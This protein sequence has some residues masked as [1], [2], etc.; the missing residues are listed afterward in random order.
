MKV[1]TA[2]YAAI[3]AALFQSTADAS[4]FNCKAVQYKDMEELVS[5][6]RAKY[7]PNETRYVDTDE[8]DMTA[9]ID[10]SYKV[11]STIDKVNRESSALLQLLNKHYDEPDVVNVAFQWA[12]SPTEVFLAVKFSNRWSSPDKQI[13]ALVVTNE[14]LDVDGNMLKYSST[15]TQSDKLKVYQ[16]VLELYDD[17]ISKETRVTPVSMG[18]FTITLTKARPAVWNRLTKRNEKIP[19]QQIWWEMKDKHQEACDKFTEES[20]DENNEL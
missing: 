7:V 14:S 2:L 11:R 6:T 1:I 10:L 19:N 20:T 15:G 4:C 13:G 18:R 17:V 16:L 12:E 8:G 3:C 9:G 5:S